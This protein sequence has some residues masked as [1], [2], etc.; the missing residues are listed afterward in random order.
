MIIFVRLK[1]TTLLENNKNKY[2]KLC[3][4]QIIKKL[5]LGRYKK[6]WK[7]NKLSRYKNQTSFMIFLEMLCKIN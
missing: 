1:C 2:V 6:M 3:Y 7:I 5:R 4:L